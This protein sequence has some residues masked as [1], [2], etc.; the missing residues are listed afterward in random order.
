MNIYKPSRK[1]IAIFLRIGKR[2]YE[3]EFNWCVYHI[4]IYTGVK[5]KFSKK[6]F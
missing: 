6:I 5:G 1:S 4:N 3:I 2:R